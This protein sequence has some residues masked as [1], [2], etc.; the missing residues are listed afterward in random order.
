VP[1]ISFGPPMV[2]ALRP[3]TKLPL[4]CH[5]MIEDPD[6]TFRPLPRL[7]RT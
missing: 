1:N 5:L 3:V 4:D 6:S 2:Q 7:E